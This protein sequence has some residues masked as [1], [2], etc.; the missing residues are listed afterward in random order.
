MNGNEVLI[1]LQAIQP[2]VKVALSSGYDENEVVQ[3]FA[4]KGLAGFLQQ[5]YMVD[6]LIN[7]VAD[8]TGE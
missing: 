1:S 3:Q 7:G 2:D 6:A 4:G 5:P 8:A